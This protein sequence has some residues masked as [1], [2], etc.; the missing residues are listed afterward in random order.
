MS[1]K[2]D[3]LNIHEQNVLAGLFRELENSAVSWESLSTSTKKRRL[4]MPDPHTK[5]WVMPCGS[6]ALIQPMLEETNCTLYALNWPC[7][8]HS[9]D[10]EGIFKIKVK[11]HPGSIQDHDG[12]NFEKEANLYPCA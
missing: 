12:S 1:I 6:C 10:K 9:L 4:L 5:T 2:V 8:C 7:G 3:Q 11:F